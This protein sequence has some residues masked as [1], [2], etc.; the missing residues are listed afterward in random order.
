MLQNSDCHLPYDLLPGAID[1]L[2]ATESSFDSGYCASPLNPSA[3]SSRQL[4]N[5]MQPMFLASPTKSP[6]KVNTDSNHMIIISPLKGIFSP[7]KDSSLSPFKLMQSPSKGFDVWDRDLFANFEENLFG[8]GDMSE[9]LVDELLKSPKGKALMEM[10]Q[11]PSQAVRRLR[12]SPDNRHKGQRFQ[13]LV[14]AHS[15]IYS[16]PQ[17]T[18]LQ[19]LDFEMVDIKE[20]TTIHDHMYGQNMSGNTLSAIDPNKM[21]ATPIKPRMTNIENAPIRKLSMMKSVGNCPMPNVVVKSENEPSVQH[22]SENWP[23]TERL[24][25]ARKQFQEILN[26]AVKRE[27][28]LLKQ[29][30]LKKAELVTKNIL[31]ENKKQLEFK[32]GKTEHHK[33]DRNLKDRVT[34]KGKKVKTYRKKKKDTY[35]QIKMALAKTTVRNQP[36]VVHR[37]LSPLTPL[38]HNTMLDPGWYPSA[39]DDDEEVEQWTGP[40]PFHTQASGSF[41]SDDMSSEEEEETPTNYQY[42][43]LS[44]RRVT[45][46]RPRLC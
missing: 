21:G 22:L 11:S 26:D 8:M 32:I 40:P 5:M 33:Q 12:I 38:I 25:F 27:I 17:T 30:K 45:I 20:E 9:N 10:R 46:K 19:C 4:A 18:G 41:Y 3:G 16:V 43:T 37:Q 2:R 6:F 31:L 14:D 44:G 36:P 42:E 23:P 1:N 34:K 29:Q 15:D 35:P 13:S 24:K 39:D 28:Q 7:F